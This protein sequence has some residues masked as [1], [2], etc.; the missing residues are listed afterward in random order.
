MDSTAAI[1]ISKK[2][3]ITGGNSYE[4]TCGMYVGCK[5]IRKE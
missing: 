3:G 2:Q 1:S 5:P 4:K